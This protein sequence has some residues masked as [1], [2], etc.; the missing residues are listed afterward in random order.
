[1][2]K[3][4]KFDLWWPLVTWPLTWPKKIDQKE[5]LAV[6]IL[7]ALSIVA[8]GVSLRGPGAELEGGRENAP[9]PAR[10]GKHR[11]TA[12]RGLKY[13]LPKTIFWS[14]KIFG[15]ELYPQHDLEV[16]S[17]F[18]GAHLNLTWPGDL[19]LWSKRSTFAHKMYAWF[20]RRHPKFGC[21]FLC[22]FRKKRW[23]RRRFCPLQCVNR[24]LAGV[25]RWARR[26]GGV[27]T[28]FRRSY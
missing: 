23:W 1:M 3:R 12:R 7:D 25:Q 21:R 16:W 18:R 28:V 24:R 13:P 14:L 6:I 15:L 9:L 11:P 22:Y 2:L 19:P 26:P 10:H 27:C 4:E 8:Y 17:R 5:K 20:V